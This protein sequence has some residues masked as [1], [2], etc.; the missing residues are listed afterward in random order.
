MKGKKTGG[1]VEGSVNKFTK[2]VKEVLTSAFDTLQEDPNVNIVKWGKE[3]PTEFYK[4]CS[5]LIPTA[6]D[7]SATVEQTTYTVKV[8]RRNE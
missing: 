7:V 2:T 1:R 5:K 6:V 3:N 8:K 4:L